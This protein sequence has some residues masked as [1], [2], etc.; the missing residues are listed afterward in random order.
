MYEIKEGFELPEEFKVKVN[1][2]QSIALQ[3]YLL[4]NGITN[5]YKENKVTDIDEGY[6]IC[7]SN[8]YVLRHKSYFIQH[9]F[10]LLRFGTYF[11]KIEITT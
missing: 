8:M 6:L 9:H 7:Y 3:K 10:E 1:R 4:A 2:K 11:K 5:G